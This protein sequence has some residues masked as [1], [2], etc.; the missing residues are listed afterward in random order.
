MASPWEAAAS[1]SVNTG[2]RILHVDFGR[3]IRIIFAFLIAITPNVGRWPNIVSH[4]IQALYHHR[5]A[6]CGHCFG[7][8]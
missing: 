5:F 1:V 2:K 3:Q 7:R 6:I 4:I 8:R